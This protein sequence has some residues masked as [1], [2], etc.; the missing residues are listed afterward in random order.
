MLREKQFSTQVFDF[1]SYLNLNE[2]LPC[3]VQAVM[4]GSIKNILKPVENKRRYCKYTWIKPRIV[5]IQGNESHM[6][7]KFELFIVS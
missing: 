6:S 5:A 1:S 3:A 4:F 2:M 7:A